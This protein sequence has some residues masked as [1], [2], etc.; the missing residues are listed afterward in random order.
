MI[1]RPPEDPEIRFWR[2]VKKTRGCWLYQGHQQKHGYCQFWTPK[3]KTIYAHVFSFRIH[4]GKL[5]KKKPLVCHTCDVGNCVRPDH[6]WAGTQKENLA[7]MIAKGRKPDLSGPRNGMYGKRSL[8]FT[9]R[10]H[11]KK[12]RL[13]MSQS[14]TGKKL[15]AE[16]IANIR[17]GRWGL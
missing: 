1:G 11:T 8:G 9:G 7:D 5:T 13:K 3:D 14:R 16:H 4:G 17:F 6:L 12:S 10:Y 15:S 2:R